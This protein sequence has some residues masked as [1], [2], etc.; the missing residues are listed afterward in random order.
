MGLL[1]LMDAILEVPIGVVV[2]QL[3]LDPVTKAQ[4]LG[5]RRTTRPHFR[6]STIS[7]WRVKVGDWGKVTKLGKELNLSSGLY[8]RIIQRS[9][10]LGPS[11]HWARSALKP[12]LLSSPCLRGQKRPLEPVW[13]GQVSPAISNFVL[14]SHPLT[15][16]KESLGRC[17]SRQ[18]LQ[19]C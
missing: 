19:H 3:P 15:S 1:S 2:E 4:L 10:A 13:L 14:R 16:Q 7:W 8:R 9:A 12:H 6:R 11:A 17:W 5:G 18:T